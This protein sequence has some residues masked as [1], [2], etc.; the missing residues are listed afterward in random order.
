MIIG[1]SYWKMNPT[2]LVAF[3][4]QLQ[5]QKYFIRS[6]LQRLQ[7][8]PPKTMKQY[9]KPFFK[10]YL[11]EWWKPICLER[12]E[13][14]EENSREDRRNIKIS[15][16]NTPYSQSNVVLY[17]QINR[18]ERPPAGRN[19]YEPKMFTRSELNFNTQYLKRLRT[20][21]QN[22]FMNHYANI[23]IYTPGTSVLP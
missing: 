17:L 6:M 12:L 15:S 23:L 13:R 21:T 2:E 11:S 8:I 5:S 19:H 22:S 4:F 10:K 16:V 14:R 9:L 18:Q 3:S 1:K 7:L 20:N